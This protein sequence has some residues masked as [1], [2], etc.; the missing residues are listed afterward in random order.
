M[1]VHGGYVESDWGQVHYRIAGASG[2]WVAL[3]HESPLSG[4][5]WEHVL[6]HLGEDARVVA[7]DTPGYGASDQ[8]P[9]ETHE[10]PEYATVL[11]RAA[12][13]L[14]MSDVVF[15][16]VHTGASLAIEAAHVFDRG[17][18]GV[19]LSGVPLFTDEERADFI[20]N[21]TPDAPYDTEGSQFGWAIQRYQHIWPDVT[22]D[23]L[24]VAVT[25]LM[26]VVDRYDWGYQAAFR[27][28]PRR[29]LATL[30][31]PVLLLDAENDMLADK[32]PLAIKLARDA[33]LVSMPGL[34]GQPH[35]RAPEAYARH[36]RNFLD[37]L[38]GEVR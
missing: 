26:R 1:R 28:D 12:S 6:A 36:L 21:W 34:P 16:G 25:E 2:P 3:F 11:A 7:F 20:A 32:D 35:V 4:R 22:A 30:E 15:G 29:P 27:H 5:V 18:T 37:E 24:H 23:A 38:G 13:E 33:R 10:I 9:S 14:G 19:V 31:H 17:T 8:P